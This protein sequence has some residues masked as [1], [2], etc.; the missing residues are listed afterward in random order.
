MARIETDAQS[1]R[2]GFRRR[3]ALT[4]CALALLVAPGAAL[5]DAPAQDQYAPPPLNAAGQGNHNAG[6]GNPGLQGPGARTDSTAG[7]S[8]AVPILFGGL[9]AV[10]A[11]ALVV[12]WRR[13]RAIRAP[14]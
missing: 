2:A 8:S 5:G 14:G 9:G 12:Y 7:N 13:R 10:A 1:R 4:A 11:A 3:V 6:A